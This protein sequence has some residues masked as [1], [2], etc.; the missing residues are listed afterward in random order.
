MTGNGIA[1]VN[2]Q[3]EQAR[4]HLTAATQRLTSRTPALGELSAAVDGAMQVTHTLAELVSTVLRQAPAILEGT[5]QR[6]LDE[7]QADLRAMHGCLTTGPLLLAP[8]RDDLH[9]LLTQPGGHPTLSDATPRHD[10]ADQKRP[11]YPDVEGATN[12][13]D[14]AL[15]T[16]ADPADV[17][18]QQREVSVLDDTEV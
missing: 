17:V 6:V 9:Q 5:H 2:G 1:P 10:V 7:L 4:H 18:D 13:I 12:G 3:L 15:V 14:T 8:A 16:E 11:V